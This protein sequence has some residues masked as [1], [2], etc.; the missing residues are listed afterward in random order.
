[1]PRHIFWA[2]IMVLM[3]NFFRHIWMSSATGSTGDLSPNRYLAGFLTLVLLGS[4]YST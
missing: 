2:L 1:M 4:L 3:I